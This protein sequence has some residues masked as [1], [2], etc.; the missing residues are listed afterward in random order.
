MSGCD[1]RGD[2][3]PFHIARSSGRT[4]S[5][6]DESLDRLRELAYRPRLRLAT[7]TDPVLR[8]AYGQIT[9]NYEELAKTMAE[10][11]H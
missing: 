2:Q 9:E 5:S 10:E 3:K 11:E 4:W 8:T 1:V 6:N 7:A